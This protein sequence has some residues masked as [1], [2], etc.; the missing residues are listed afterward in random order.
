M[1][2]FGFLLLFI[3]LFIYSECLNIHDNCTLSSECSISN[4][5]CHHGQCL[6]LPDFKEINNNCH[7]IDLDSKL[8]KNC[9]QS[10]ECTGIGEYCSSFNICVCLSTHVEVSSTCLP[11]ILP[12]NKKC[13]TSSQCN[14]GFPGSYCNDT[15]KIC[16]CPDG[17]TMK[18][19]TCIL[20]SYG[21][22]LIQADNS[23]STNTINVAK[24]SI[25]DKITN[26]ITLKTRSIF[27]QQSETNDI[28]GVRPGQYCTEDTACSGYP[29]AY[30]DG[31]CKCKEG[32]YDAGS[33]CISHTA[34]TQPVQGSCPMGQVY[35]SEGGTCINTVYPGD[36]CQYSEQCSAIESGSFCR[37]NICEC[38]Y[39][40][41]KSNDGR[42]C[43]YKDN[44]CL[45]KG[46]I[47][48][49]ELGECKQVIIPGVESCSHSLQ[50]ST[51]FAGAYCYERRCTCPQLTPY[52]VDGTC[53]TLCFEG[54]SF[55]S[56]TGSCLPNV[57]PGSECT[58]TSQC[59]ATYPGV[60]CSSGICKCG[61][62]K[63]FTGSSCE[64]SCPSGYMKGNNNICVPGCTPNQIE[65]NGE[66]LSYAAPGQIC[67]V[68]AQ[69][70]GNSL[71]GNGICT[72]RSN[73][74]IISGICQIIK[75]FPEQSCALGEECIGGSSCI[76]GTCVCGP[77]T[78]NVN[79]QCIKP[80]PVPPNS[81]CTKATLCSGGSYCVDNVCTCESPLV[82]INNTCS[83]PP[84]VLPLSPCPTG[85][86][87]C[88]GGSS[89]VQSICTCP[90]GTIAE[91]GECHSILYVNV[92]QTCSESRICSGH[93]ICLDF[94]CVC[95]SPYF[96]K[97][98]ECVLPGT[99]LVG[100][101][102]AN[103]Q[104][105]TDNAY[106]DEQKKICLC[107]PPTVNQNGICILPLESNPGEPCDSTISC[108]GF[109]NCVNNVCTCPAGTMNINN[110]CKQI[111]DDLGDCSTSKECPLGSYC[112]EGTLKCLCASGT[113]PVDGNCVPNTVV[114]NEV[115]NSLT[116]YPSN[117]RMNSM[118]RIKM[119]PLRVPPGGN[120]LQN[121]YKCINGADCVAG[122][123]ICPYDTRLVNGKCTK[124]LFAF[125]GEDCDSG[126]ECT[127]NSVCNHETLKCEC[128]NTSKIAVGRSCVDRLRSHP[129]YPCDNGEMCIG[130]SVCFKGSCKCP[131][132]QV[133]V[134]KVCVEQRRLMPGNKCSDD[135]IC[136]GNS[137]CDRKTMIC[138]CRPHH[139]PVNG[140][141]TKII[142]SKPGET[143]IGSQ[144][145]CILN[146]YCN[147]T[148]CV[149]LPEMK[150]INGQCKV[151]VRRQPGN[152]CT[153]GEECTGLS[154][155]IKGK[156]TCNSPRILKGY[157]CELPTEVPAG[158]SC[159]YQDICLGGSKCVNGRCLCEINEFVRSGICIQK[160][161]KNPG[162]SCN[163]HQICNGG[164]Y[165]SRSKTC[166][167]YQGF[168]IENS[169]CV[170]K[171]RSNPGESC[172]SGERC[173]GNS[174]CLREVCTCP[175][176]TTQQGDKCVSTKLSKIGE[177]CINNE[178]CTNGA[179]CQPI[180]KVCACPPGYVNRNEACVPIEGLNSK[181]E[182]QIKDYFYSPERSKI[183]QPLFKRKDVLRRSEIESP[184]KCKNN[185]DCDENAKCKNNVCVC[186]HNYV[187]KNGFC[188][189]YVSAVDPP[190]GGSLGHKCTN[191]N[192]CT[193][194]NSYCK[195][196]RCICQPGYR[197]LGINQCIYGKYGKFSRTE[198]IKMKE[199]ND[200]SIE[201]RPSLPGGKCIESKDCLNKSFCHQGKCVCPRGMKTI[202]SN[203]VE[204]ETV[205]PLYSCANGE[206]C[207]GNSECST[208]KICLCPENHTLYKGF[209]QTDEQIQNMKKLLEKEVTKGKGL[210]PIPNLKIMNKVSLLEKIEMMINK[211]K[212][213]TTQMPK[214]IIR[215][216]VTT[217]IKPRKF[218]PLPVIPIVQTSKTV[219]SFKLETTSIPS[220][221]PTTKASSVDL[222]KNSSTFVSTVLTSN[223]PEINLTKT[224][225]AIVPSKFS[226]TN[227]PTVFSS[228][229]STTNTP[230]IFSSKTSTTNTP[231]VFP[232]EAS[233]TNT[234]I[235][236]STKTPS[237]S[238]TEGIT[239]L[240]SELT[241]S[242]T[243]TSTKETPTLLT[244]TTKFSKI[245]TQTNK[246]PTAPEI[247]PITASPINITDLI[248]NV[249][250]SNEIL[251]PEQVEINYIE[252]PSTTT[253]SLLLTTEIDKTLESNLNITSIVEEILSIKEP[254]TEILEE[255][256]EITEDESEEEVEVQ[257]IYSKITERPFESVEFYK[258]F[259]NL[260]S[261]TYLA[262][263]NS[264]K[265][266]IVPYSLFQISK[267]GHFCDDAIVFC[268]NNST[269]E[270]N[271]CQF[272]PGSSC[273][274]GETCIGGSVCQDNT[275]TCPTD[276]PYIV[277]D[278][279]SSTLNAVPVG[280]SELKNKSIVLK[281]PIDK[282]NY[283][284]NNNAPKINEISRL[285]RQT[286]QIGLSYECTNSTLN[287]VIVSPCIVNAFCLEG[288]CQ[289]L[290]NFIQI[291]NACFSKSIIGNVIKE[292]GE[293]CVSTDFCNGGS[294]CSTESGICVC[295]QDTV[296]YNSHCVRKTGVGEGSPCNS[297]QQC[298]PN[299]VCINGICVKST[300]TGNETIVEVSPGNQCPTIT[301]VICKCIGN[302]VLANNYCV[303]PSGEKIINGYCVGTDSIANPGET[304]YP[305][306]TQCLGD[307]ICIDN[308]CTCPNGFVNINKQCVSLSTTIEPEITTTTTVSVYPL[309]PTIGEPCNIQIGCRNGAVCL[310]GICQC[311]PNTDL[312]N[313]QCIVRYQTANPGEPCSSAGIICI[314]GSACIN[315]ICTCPQGSYILNGICVLGSL[316]TTRP[317]M[318]EVIDPGFPCGRP[319]TRC[320]GG[321]YCS[322]GLCICP[323][324]FVP[325]KNICVEYSP[326]SGPLITTTS[327]TPR[328]YTPLFPG[329]V[330]GMALSY[331]TGG[332]YCIDGYCQCTQG[333]VP[334]GRI[335]SDVINPTSTMNPLTTLLPGESCDAVCELLKTCTKYCG[336]G[337]I[338]IGGICTCGMGY[339]AINGVCQINKEYGYGNNVVYAT[340]NPTWME[341]YRYPGQD[342]NTYTICTGG[343]ACDGKYC[344]CPTGFVPTKNDRSCINSNYLSEISKGGAIEKSTEVVRLYKAPEISSI[345]RPYKKAK[346]SSRKKKC[347]DDSQCDGGMVCNSV[348]S[349]C[350][351]PSK[352]T[353][354]NGQCLDLFAGKLAYPGSKCLSEEDPES[355]IL[356]CANGSEC[357]K[358]V[359]YCTCPKGTIP[360]LESF[361]VSID[362]ADNKLALPGKV[363][364]I[365]VTP[366]CANN[367]ICQDGFCVCPYG[368]KNN[369]NGVCS[370]RV[371]VN[372]TSILKTFSRKL[373]GDKCYESKECI[374]PGECKKFTCQCPPEMIVSS[375]RTCVNKRK[376]SKIGDY[377][378]EGAGIFCVIVNSECSNHYC[379]CKPN[380]IPIRINNELE[381]QNTMH[382]A[383]D[384]VINREGVKFEGNIYDS[385]IVQPIENSLLDCPI[386]GSCS[387]PDCFCSTSGLNIP[388]NIQYHETPQ[389]I[390]LTFDGPITDR[391][392]NIYKNIFSGKHKNK[393]NCP[394]KG[395]FFVSHEFN[396][397]DQTQWLHSTGHEIGV[398][399]ITHRTLSDLSEEE[400]DEEMSGLRE[401]LEKFSYI[402]PEKIKGV[403]APQLGMGG[404]AQ[405]TMMETMNFLY[406]NSQT[407]T[408]GPY[409]PQSLHYKTPWKCLGQTCPNTSHD[410]WEFPINTLIRDDGKNALFMLQA[411]TRFDSPEKISNMLLR[412]LEKH[413]RSNKAPFIL[414]IESDFLTALPFNGAFQAL[415][416]FITK[417]LQKND[418]Y[419]VTMEQALTWIQRPTRLVKLP[420]FSPWQCR[421]YRNE[422][423]RPCETPSICSYDDSPTNYPHSFR[424]CGSCPNVYP[425]LR[426]PIGKGNT[427]I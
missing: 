320:G 336:G 421:R 162:E 120:C 292:P 244:S 273:Q 246:I 168:V 394:I 283:L 101:N 330:C 216:K 356:I 106:C 55:S 74:Q 234:P 84:S 405:F 63:V 227:I 299:L 28:P 148:T 72:C 75:V 78:V 250:K 417:A 56:I 231:T 333:Q 259:P 127:R 242:S 146:S 65:H 264:T 328:Q 139:V 173:E 350:Q 163:E 291:N 21:I 258:I 60:I 137:E 265:A 360:N 203:C 150:I 367:A 41:V 156:C 210:V 322:G 138:Q 338:C 164:S 224:S 102:C 341:T 30:C 274:H 389:M 399:S 416:K 147:G 124:Q 80:I 176:F 337:S 230:T 130:G 131:A 149:C 267:A 26:F 413:L 359:G 98:G 279:C 409:W 208:N 304:C 306:I 114:S 70:T 218:T 202:R 76:D 334:L 93:S 144:Y 339:V 10:S 67:K 115:P 33:T 404:E 282:T 233:T 145:R 364:N 53:G 119:S 14:Y 327:T 160:V 4:S 300:T 316:T 420:N 77:G 372:E 352:L 105:C 387:L 314:G 174:T 201:R 128:I 271:I 206:I 373:I 326:G 151:P 324:N 238:T 355:Q 165:C 225:L 211:S 16:E 1:P 228:E 29:L 69:C 232:S 365:K 268:S 178:S 221:I 104:T 345:I 303:C 278:S 95:P 111:Q 266:S 385:F 376:K 108:T 24:A 380:F 34:A 194:D 52:A 425:W 422:H 135:D 354:F 418:T 22:P 7:P 92:T 357:N 302:S 36:S 186:N 236:D 397:Y 212:E 15:T 402:D 427:L 347:Y 290:Y 423:Q 301:G 117:S 332:S 384:L 319:F 317:L 110:I 353:N 129:G 25:F 94:T 175:R 154:T 297:T 226:T 309:L 66:C 289:C 254:Y 142:L 123:C 197:K 340:D 23:V 386:D 48:V 308:I 257:P 213:T 395:T 183:S 190:S 414:N 159:N 2:K 286:S 369:G 329:D 13:L 270:Q 408:D 220:T 307:S 311:P 313:G 85:L 19:N 152:F 91:K 88:L 296:L 251:I 293:A 157:K 381:C 335:C 8:G 31:Y 62:D 229:A 42:S 260:I 17:T 310:N 50:C 49:P 401:A 196:G 134:N 378:D 215:Q 261:N 325:I 182:S 71:C 193:V 107:I 61:K 222:V 79:N 377:C 424:V 89:C 285:K 243:I 371:T 288:Y 32:S 247:V 295:G 269:C 398:N 235:I 280:E 207:T 223:A 121:H 172:K 391:V 126:Q 323:P 214:T 188:I 255:E 192:D 171:T 11:V 44:H 426:D 400:W 109:S 287:G 99:S 141:C 54:Q 57:Y 184:A 136:T 305:N 298:G 331:C 362:K 185:S 198:P 276:K 217:T 118:K 374:F 177:T 45:T 170:K 113:V 73:M 348:T 161:Y 58:Y 382:D 43:V 253:E 342:C 169:K 46:T 90:V 263:T 383:S 368:T 363:C 312:I 122:I 153:E 284:I 38:V 390:I 200:L 116:Y 143:C 415:D 219:D 406:D 39:G 256:E 132:N 35:I 167:C 318:W 237:I 112:D 272:N 407:T 51:A 180:S 6:C 249:V 155:C 403:R 68:N 419:F 349:I 12:G 9:S 375:E 181:K 40:M 410:V 20:S 83:Y 252:Q 388:G 412:N 358:I 27:N 351:C 315:N 187:L 199:E 294:S 245:D 37:N 248:I 346:F 209:C 281:I 262:K 97:G 344:Q 81:A 5:S 158:G 370:P 204:V 189:R 86:E 195:Y 100:Q 239:V 64:T 379:R 366:N 392:I 275:C 205:P 82:P 87:K 18:G 47:W 166:V 393:N 179:K 125:P 103:K 240:T 241:P 277:K 59:H 191:S 411:V 396:N 96:L 343:S 140:I 321:S 3:Q 361:C 133:A